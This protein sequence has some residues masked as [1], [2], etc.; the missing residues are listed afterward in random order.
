MKQKRLLWF[1]ILLV[2]ALLSRFVLPE[3]EEVLPEGLRVFYIDVG[4][5]DS[6]Y[7]EFPGGKTCLIDA[8]EQQES[9]ALM[10]FL[11]RRDTETIDYVICTHPHSDH[12][13]GMQTVIEHFEIG[14]IYMPKAVHTSK[15]YEDLLRA[16]QKKGHT[17]HTARAGVNI[18]PEEEVSLEIVAPCNTF[19]E[20]LNDYS[21]VVRI[22]YGETAFLFT[23]DAEQLSENEILDS[24]VPIWANVLKVGHHGSSTS[25][26]EAFLSAVSPEWAVISVGEDNSYGH[27]HKEVLSR[28]E[29]LGI[30]VKRTDRDGTVMAISD[31]QQ[32]QIH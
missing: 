11:A 18:A 5:G 29:T 1:L 32:V 14:E 25:N 4:Q 24:G 13:G 20:E 19:Y 23:G 12:I 9:D 10:S 17:I 30:Q 15:T 28:L 26:S 22:T 21:A 27:P 3:T 7:I 6:T 16:I 31:G 8:G 2:C